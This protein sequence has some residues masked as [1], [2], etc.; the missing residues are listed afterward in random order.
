VEPPDGGEDPFIKDPFDP[1][2]G[3]DDLTGEYDG[4]DND[5]TV[6]EGNESDFPG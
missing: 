3:E 2:F 4:T 5:S 1:D 6:F